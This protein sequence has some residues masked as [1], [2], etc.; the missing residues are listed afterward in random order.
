MDRRGPPLCHQGPQVNAA[1]GVPQSGRA[2]APHPGCD[3]FSR[4]PTRVYGWAALKKRWF[5]H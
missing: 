4:I 3:E 5:F 1:R 2:N